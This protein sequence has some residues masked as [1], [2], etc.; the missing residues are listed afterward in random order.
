METIGLAF[1]DWLVII[2]YFAFVIGLGFYL[3]RYT[4]TDTDFF[5]AG[6]KNSSWV[7]GIAFL[8][9]NLG[10]LAGINR[11]DR[12]YLQVRNVCRPLLLDRCDSG[13]AVSGHLHDAFL[14]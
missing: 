12:Q 11:N 3:K 7:A 13:H 6:R 5:L 8:S 10:A 1:A 4:K 14:L 9:A 2:L